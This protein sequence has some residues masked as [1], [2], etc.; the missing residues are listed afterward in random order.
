MKLARSRIS[1]LTLLDITVPPQL[2]TGKKL[3]RRVSGDPLHQLGAYGSVDDAAEL[4]LG[5]GLILEGVPPVRPLA[6]PGEH[7]P[8]RQVE[9]AQPPRLPGVAA[10]AGQDLAHE[11]RPA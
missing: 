10:L 9:T 6:P 8:R 1:S 11:R 2:L 5:A 3:S 4:P 7:R